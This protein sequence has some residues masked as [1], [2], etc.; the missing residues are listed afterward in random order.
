MQIRCCSCLSRHSRLTYLIKKLHCHQ[1]IRMS[2]CHALSTESKVMDDM[3]PDDDIA[4]AL[5]D[6]SSYN[7]LLH[8]TTRAPHV[9]QTSREN[10]ISTQ[11]V[12]LTHVA[13]APGQHVPLEWESL[14]SSEQMLQPS[15]RITR[16][17]RKATSAPI[18]RDNF[19]SEH[20]C[21]HVLSYIGTEPSTEQKP[22]LV[23]VLLRVECA[24]PLAHK[25]GIH[26]RD[27]VGLV[28]SAQTTMPP[29]QGIQSCF[30]CVPI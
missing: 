29:F 16:P 5:D 17:R 13:T 15:G 28:Y 3:V 25:V 2:N 11:A 27:D 24:M 30:R 12:E 22:H 8:R 9:E 6:D 23:A 14:C 7:C 19:T 26:R 10:I 18:T 4:E 1:K 21:G 20:K